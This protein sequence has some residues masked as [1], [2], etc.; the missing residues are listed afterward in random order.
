GLL[1]DESVHPVPN[2]ERSATIRHHLPVKAHPAILV[3]FVDS[4]QDFVIRLDAYKFSRLEVERVQRAWL[5][6]RK[7]SPMPGVGEAS[8]EGLESIVEPAGGAAESAAE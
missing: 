6:H 2:A 3:V 4:E 1:V 5:A 8:P 7:F